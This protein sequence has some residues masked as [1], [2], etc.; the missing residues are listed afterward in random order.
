[1]VVD[2]L[3]NAVETE[4]KVY[5][6]YGEGPFGDARFVR[7]VKLEKDYVLCI[8]NDDDEN[9]DWK[10]FNYSK[11]SRVTIVEPL[12]DDSPEIIPRKKDFV[13]EIYDEI[14]KDLSGETLEKEDMSSFSERL[15]GL[16]DTF[17][18]IIKKE[19]KWEERKN[20]AIYDV[21]DRIAKECIVF[22]SAHHDE[23]ILS[24]IGRMQDTYIRKNTDYGDSFSILYKEDGIITVKVRLPDKYRRF[25]TLQKRERLV[26]DETIKDTLL[27]M[28]GY[29]VLA[30]KEIRHE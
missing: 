1:M 5:L 21:L 14:K 29:S 17:C 27:D 4:R 8:T 26:K 19:D 12:E 6:V 30:M 18:S 20:I 9:P 13:I 15:T 2:I 3:R 11:I 22:L 28:V 25:M 23:T 10:R 7:P 16:Y 24:L